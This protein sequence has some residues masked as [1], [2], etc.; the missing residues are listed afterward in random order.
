MEI[1]RCKSCNIKFEAEGRKVEWVDT[2]F[3]PCGRLVAICPS[4]N[5]DCDEFRLPRQAGNSRYEHSH[6]PVCSSCCGGCGL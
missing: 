3:G 6:S 2:T 4:C 5:T 1:Y